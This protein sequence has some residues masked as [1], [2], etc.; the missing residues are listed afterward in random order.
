[1]GA[2]CVC[3][4]V[5][6][7]VGVGVGVGGCWKGLGGERKRRGT[8]GVLDVAKEHKPKRLKQR[9]MGW[10]EGEVSFLFYFSRRLGLGRRKLRTGKNTRER[11][12]WCNNWGKGNGVHQPRVEITPLLQI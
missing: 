5:G 6:G 8:K 9:P 2:W 10:R 12:G 11:V 7:W 3:V 1:V 4:Y